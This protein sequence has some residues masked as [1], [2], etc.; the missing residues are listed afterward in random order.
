VPR[1]ESS[2]VK[3][4][5]QP[6]VGPCST[7]ASLKGKTALG[8]SYSLESIITEEETPKS[9]GRDSQETLTQTTPVLPQRISGRFL[10][11][12]KPVPRMLPSPRIRE[13]EIVPK[14]ETDEGLETIDLTRSVERVPSIQEPRSP[15]PLPPALPKPSPTIQKRIKRTRSLSLAEK[16]PFARA[17]REA[18]ALPKFAYQEVVRKKDER[19]HLHASDCP[20]C[21]DVKFIIFAAPIF[22]LKQTRKNS[23]I[24]PL[25]YRIK[26]CGRVD[27]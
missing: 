24:K 19:K 2:V 23:F 27:W 15:A 13:Q 22:S 7:A 21:R 4:E 20:C 9:G 3:K 25:D 11:L 26:S 10:P 18:A 12:E 1:H 6:L 5:D 16:L 17:A 8:R 14:E